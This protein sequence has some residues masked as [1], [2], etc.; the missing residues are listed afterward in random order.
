MFSSLMVAEDTLL[1]YR[2]SVI[3]STQHTATLARYI[4]F[5]AALPAAIPLN[6]GCFKGYTLKARHVKCNVTE[7][8]REFQS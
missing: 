7:S 2:A 4:F 5:Y 3:S 1:P 6:N 8:C